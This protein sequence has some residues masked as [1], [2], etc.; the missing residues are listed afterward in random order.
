MLTEL[1]SRV[2]RQEV[3]AFHSGLN[4]IIGDPEAANSLGKSTLLMVIDFVMGGDAFLEHNVDVI[5]ELGHHSYEFTLEFDRKY[6]FSRAT[7]A[8]FVVDICDANY[9]VV[10][11]I[12]KS[13]YL[14]FLH[15]K[16]VEGLK[17]LTFRAAIGPYTRVWPK[18]NVMMVKRPLHSASTQ[19]T[20]VCVE[21]LIKLFD[22]FEQISD[23]S[24]ATAQKIDE[25]S[26]LKAAQANQIV[27]KINKAHYDANLQELERLNA[28]IV[29]I[30]SEMAKYAVNVKQL[31]DRDLLDLKYQ[32]DQLLGT[33]F[34]VQQRLAV[35]K[36]NLGKQKKVSQSQFVELVKYFPDVDVDRLA[37]VEQ[38]HS[39]VTLLLKDE[40]KV[41]ERSLE[42]RLSS[43]DQQISQ[44]D[45]QFSAK[46]SNH[47]NPSSL[48][49]RVISLSNKYARLSDE[50]TQF[51]KAKEILGDLGELK[52]KLTELKSAVVEGISEEINCELESIVHRVYGDDGKVP[53]FTLGESSYSYNVFDD[54]GT[55]KAF[56]SLVI[57]DLAMLSLT[58]L[59]LVLHDLPL[60]KNVENRAVAGIVDE[61]TRHANKQCFVVLDEITKYGK[62]TAEIVESHSVIHL[63]NRFQ[64]YVKD[65]RRAG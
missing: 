2:F 27:P 3:I 65:W 6:Y 46:L 49:D 56:A 37:Q 7:N 53:Q 28:E 51:E 9:E 16:Y 21:N 1:R 59:P 34:K 48:I 60:F 35:T 55:G 36:R 14:D 30:R 19:K 17:N 25:N 23:V 54:T 12:T 58:D 47:D 24:K 4:T 43:I 62:K 15:E 33:R 10:R 22:E 50:N 38:F 61:Y 44:L 32:K 45:M 29:E 39:R 52:R 18:E 64:L 5:Q 8:A 57:F 26:A 40:L 41:A 11:S 13:A 63:A 42:T 20:E 31:L